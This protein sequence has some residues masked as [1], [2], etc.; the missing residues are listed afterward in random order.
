[1]AK[2][3]ILLVDD[4]SMIRQGLKSFLEEAKI[5]VVDEAKN[6]VEALEKLEQIEIKHDF[7]L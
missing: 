7:I 6:G 4:H 1:M 5:T 3:K 2:I